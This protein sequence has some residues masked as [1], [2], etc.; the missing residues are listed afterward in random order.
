MTPAASQKLRTW[1]QAWLAE[2]WWSC[3]AALT[4]TWVTIRHATPTTPARKPHP[5]QM[6]SIGPTLGR[7]GTEVVRLRRAD[8]K[9][10]KGMLLTS[11]A[12][13]RQGPA[14]AQVPP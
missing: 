3:M 12:G 9:A 6:M 10:E 4:A 1:A 8:L 2:T 5:L 7:L 13:R 14:S 11:A